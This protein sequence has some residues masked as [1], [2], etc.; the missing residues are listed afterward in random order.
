MLMRMALL[1]A[2]SLTAYAGGE[3]HELYEFDTDGQRL[4]YQ[5]LSETLRCPKCQNQNLADSASEIS[6]TMRDVIAEK[7]LEGQS[8]KEIKKLMV[9]SYGDFVLYEPPRRKETAILWFGP[10]IVFG[11]VIVFFV[12]IVLKRSKRA[13]KEMLDDSNA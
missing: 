4:A 13:S 3:P 10:P 9:D 2:V 6:K 11:V 12:V 1:C 5:N 8:E 7:L